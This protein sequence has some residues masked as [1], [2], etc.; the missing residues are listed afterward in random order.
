[1]VYLPDSD[2]HLRD[3]LGIPHDA[4]VFGRHGGFDTF[5]I[6]FV[7]CIIERILQ[8][9]DDYYFI[10]MN[11][12][13]FLKRKM[14]DHPRVI[15][16]PASYD[17]SYKTA[18]INT[19]DAMIHAR[20]GGE[21][22]GLAVGE[23]SIRNKPVL[24]WDIP[25]G[26]ASVRYHLWHTLLSPLIPGQQRLPKKADTAHLNILGHKARVYHNAI[27]LYKL[28]DAFDP[29]STR[30]QNWDAYSQSYSPQ[31]VMKLFQKHFLQSE[32]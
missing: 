12:R 20:K 2:A 28:I 22:F 16:L 27:E 11:T 18:F 13:P 17:S 9:R 21:T 23:F 29:I 7:H 8:E 19:C 1:M 5:N 3:D 24:T 6:H 10:F 26:W 30:K 4:I 14:R 25:K 15:H 32:L 31:S